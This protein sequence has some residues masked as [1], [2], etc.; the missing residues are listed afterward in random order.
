MI[1]YTFFLNKTIS[2]FNHK[3]NETCEKI[4][5]NINYKIA[6]VLNNYLMHTLV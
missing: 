2:L 3:N 6:T 4:M 5:I 1:H